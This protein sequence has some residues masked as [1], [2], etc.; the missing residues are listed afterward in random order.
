MGFNPKKIVTL[1]DLAKTL[2]V[3][4][5]TVSY[6]LSRRESEVGI[7]KDTAKRVREIARERGYVSN[8]WA[9]SLR[10]SKT[11]MVSV[12]FTSFEKDFA[13]RAMDSIETVLMENKYASAVASHCYTAPFF[14]DD[15]SGFESYQLFSILKRRDEGVLCQPRSEEFK[16][17]YIKLMENGIPVVFMGSVL[18]DMTGLEKV[19]SVTW[20]CKDAARNVV[21]HLVDQGSKRIAFVSPTHGVLS[22]HD[23]YDAYKQ[24]LAES[25]L[26]LR[27]D[28]VYWSPPSKPIE[29]DAVMSQLFGGNEAPDAIF[30]VNDA[31]A[32]DL[33]KEFKKCG[34]SVPG[35]VKLAGLGD[36]AG[37]DLA[38][39]T[40][41]KEPIGQ[42]GACGVR[43]LLDNINSVEMNPVNIKID[44]SEVIVRSSTM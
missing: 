44:S 43:I 13:A 39:I 37:S 18:D 36:I 19:S 31:T 12:L 27:Q 21:R 23:R 41:V 42:I 26:P 33:F 16:G 5:T 11:G 9:Q 35:R 3:S 4:K 30:A 22:D 8:R 25:G 14:H 7:S 28:M 32:V 38:E 6:S 20:N 15:Y 29:M 2:K 1:A 24:V 17:D 10:N 34:I 40:T